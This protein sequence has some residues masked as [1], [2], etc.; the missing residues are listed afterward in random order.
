M[1]DWI[2]VD[3]RLP[4]EDETVIVAGGIGYVIDGVWYSA[5]AEA[6]G[7]PIQWEVTHWMDL[8]ELPK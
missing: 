2:S 4:D 7:R 8:P 6:N 5:T 3:D 1:S